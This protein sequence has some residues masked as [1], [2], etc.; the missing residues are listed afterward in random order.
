MSHVRDYK[1]GTLWLTMARPSL[2]TNHHP[3]GRGQ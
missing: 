3:N 1:F 2:V